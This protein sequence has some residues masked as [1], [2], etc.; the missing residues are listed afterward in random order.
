MKYSIKIHTNIV[1]NFEIGQA[2]DNKKICFITNILFQQEDEVM[3][4]SKKY[5]NENCSKEQIK[6]N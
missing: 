4:E 3:L 5:D 2:A 1:V 6:H